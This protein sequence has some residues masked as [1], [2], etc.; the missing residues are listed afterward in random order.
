MSVLAF[1][2]QLVGGQVLGD[3]LTAWVNNL[4]ENEGFARTDAYR[5]IT[6]WAD[7]GDPSIIAA[8]GQT[9]VRRADVDAD[10]APATRLF[11]VERTGLDGIFA[12]YRDLDRAADESDGGPCGHNLKEEYAP[13]N[14]ASHGAELPLGVLDLYELESWFPPEFLL[15]GCTPKEANTP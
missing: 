7:E 3:H 2:N 4:V 8:T 13:L 9:W 14:D 11:I 15:P 12:L 10:E 1:L 5:C 6:E